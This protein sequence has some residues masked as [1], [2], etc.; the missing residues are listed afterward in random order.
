MFGLRLFQ[1]K[2]GPLCLLRLLKRPLAS[3]G[4]N[5]PEETTGQG[6]RW[7][8]SLTLSFPFFCRFTCC[9]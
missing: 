9:P 5:L 3:S 1:L 8:A 4:A 7:P 6:V 2:S